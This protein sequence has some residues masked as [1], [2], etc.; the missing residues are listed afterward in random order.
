VTEHET[1]SI[2]QETTFTRDVSDDKTL[3]RTLRELSEEVGRSLRRNDLAGRTVRLKLRWPDFTTL[4][5]QTTLPQPTDREEEIVK[6]ALALLK[7]VRR[8]GQPV[9]L[10]GVGVSG[11]GQPVRQLSLWEAGDERARRLEG[12]I[13]ELQ[14]KY[15]KK[16]IHRGDLE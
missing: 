11:L 5:R 4:T 9:R 7:S 13:D 10:I 2:S 16:A 14:A 15:G 12:V 3:E 6:T 1:K 8:A